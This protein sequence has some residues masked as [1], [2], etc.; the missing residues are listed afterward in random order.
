MVRQ[1]G[2]FTLMETIVA[3]V[4]FSSI[5]IALYKGLEKGGASIRQSGMDAAASTLALSLLA[6][7]GVEN[8]LA[9]GQ[10]YSGVEDRF[11][12][13]MSVRQAGELD[14]AADASSKAT[15]FWVDVEI[16]WREGARQEPRTAS[17]RTLKLGLRS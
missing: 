11:S 2:G 8:A 7:A 15:T 10:V 9:N 14:T 5:F 16:S 1:Q 6:S 13:R 17:Y 12:W 4:L 3:L